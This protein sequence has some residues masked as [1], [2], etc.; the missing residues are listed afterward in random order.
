[1]YGEAEGMYKHGVAW[2]G[3]DAP[4]PRGVLRDQIRHRSQIRA[5]LTLWWLNK[6]DGF[7]IGAGRGG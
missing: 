1:M 4:I 5:I 2:L 7:R 6:S 3:W